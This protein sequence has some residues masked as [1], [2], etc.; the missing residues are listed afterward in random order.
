MCGEPCLRPRWLLNH[1]TINQMRIKPG[2][3]T[4]LRFIHTPLSLE[5][6]SYCLLSFQGNIPQ[7]IICLLSSVR[8]PVFSSSHTKCQSIIGPCFSPHSL[9]FSLSLSSFQTTSCI[10][11]PVLAPYPHSSIS[12]VW[13]Y[14]PI[15]QAKVWPRWH[16]KD[17][18]AL[19]WPA[20]E[21]DVYMYPNL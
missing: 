3:S 8:L 11:N 12:L 17:G 21:F 9:T 4:A 7:S 14:W 18:K 2:L 15:N 13:S 5:T 6:P 20:D 19:Y 1:R 10:I 16:P